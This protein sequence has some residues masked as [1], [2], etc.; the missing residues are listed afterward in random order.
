MLNQE[1]I[2]PAVSWQELQAQDL[3]QLS[4][5]LGGPDSGKTYLVRWLA[6]MMLD[7]GET[8]AWI[9]G[10]I[11]QNFLGLPTT[12]NMALLWADREMPPPV[13]STF[14]VGSTKAQGRSLALITGLK[15]LLELAQAKGV[16]KV[17]M[18]TTGFI[19]KASGGLD[20]KKWKLELLRPQNIICLQSDRELEPV[21]APWRKHPDLRILE[22]G[23]AP[24]LGKKTTEK[25]LQNRRRKFQEYF[26]GATRHNLLVSAW[27]VHDLHLA[28]R[29]SLVG[30][31][32]QEGFCVGLGVILEKSGQEIRICTALDS[33]AQVA[34]LRVGTIRVDPGTGLELA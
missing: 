32:D 34:A 7:S 21:L 5:I 33:L 16:K 24:G 30:L 22:P 19:D 14:F 18:D 29:L 6:Q 2:I 13:H 26:K 12:I 31:L 3:P 27:P 8:A 4:I 11:G 15:R 17:L 20:L 25:R 10:D 23:F 9:D 28:R 1:E